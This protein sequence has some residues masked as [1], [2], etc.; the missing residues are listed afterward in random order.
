[1]SHSLTDWAWLFI[2]EV[3]LTEKL[4]FFLF[5]LSMSA[6]RCYQQQDLKSSRKKSIGISSLLIRWEM[7]VGALYLTFWKVTVWTRLKIAKRLPCRNK[8]WNEWGTS[9]Y[10]CR[11]GVGGEGGGKKKRKICLEDQNPFLPG[12]VNGMWASSLI[13]Y[14]HDNPSPC[15]LISPLLCL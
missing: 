2:N 12:H 8:N 4:F 15:H 10:I 5:Q 1:M 14:L 7:I 11:K 13:K 6:E 9:H 3:V